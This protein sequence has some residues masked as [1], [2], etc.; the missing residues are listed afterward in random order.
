MTSLKE[1]V[2]NKVYERAQ[3]DLENFYYFS[4]KE[5]FKHFFRHSLSIVQQKNMPRTRRSI[6]LYFHK[7]AIRL[8]YPREEF[9]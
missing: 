4:Y 1:N 9:L 8:F 2:S 5:T 3:E 6:F 7:I